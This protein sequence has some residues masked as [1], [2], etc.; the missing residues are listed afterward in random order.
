MGEDAP[1]L[2]STLTGS[3]IGAAQKV[4]RVLGHG[5]LEKVYQNALRL[6]LEALGLDVQA[7][8]PIEVRYRAGWWA[9][10]KRICW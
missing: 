8:A 4:Y 3:I 5:F 2:H 9:S 1:R 7:E 10:T 6:E